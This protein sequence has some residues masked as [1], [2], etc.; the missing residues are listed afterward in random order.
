MARGFAHGRIRPDIKGF[1]VT[2]GPVS[3]AGMLADSGT[4]NETFGDLRKKSSAINELPGL[5]LELDAKR[6]EA[7]QYADAYAEKAKWDTKTIDA[8]YGSAADGLTAQGN[9]A[10][11]SGSW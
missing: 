11:K 6:Y 3:K 1:Q 7:D 10:R 5:G 8:K 2:G 9:T 4:L